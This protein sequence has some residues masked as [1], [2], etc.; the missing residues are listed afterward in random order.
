MARSAIV[1]RVEQTPETT[2]VRSEEVTRRLVEHTVV[3]QRLGEGGDLARDRG[4]L[5]TICFVVRVVVP[6]T[7]YRAVANRL[8]TRAGEKMGAVFT[9]AF[10]AGLAEPGGGGVGVRAVE[11][12]HVLR[13]I[14][15]DRVHV[16]VGVARWDRDRFQV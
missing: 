10:E 14:P 6:L 7:L 4:D 8:A 16:I 13:D 3:V 11:R 15:K 5:S 2:D 9:F 1:A 12:L